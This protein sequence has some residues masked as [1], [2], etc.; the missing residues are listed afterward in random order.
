[1]LGVEVEDLHIL[2]SLVLPSCLHLYCILLPYHLSC[3]N[4]DMLQDQQGI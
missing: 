1:M 4:C 2:S 3:E